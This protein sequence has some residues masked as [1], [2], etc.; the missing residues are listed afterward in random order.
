MATGEYMDTDWEIIREI[1]WMWRPNHWETAAKITGEYKILSL[2]EFIRYKLFQARGNLKK[3][4]LDTPW[5]LSRVDS[6]HGNE[7]ADWRI[8][9]VSKQTEIDMLFHNLSRVMDLLMSVIMIVHGMKTGRGESLRRNFFGSL[10]NSQPFIHEL[11]QKDPLLAG[12]LSKIYDSA[13]N[14]FLG[15]YLQNPETPMYPQRMMD[16]D[17][18]VNLE[19]TF[20]EAADQLGR[21]IINHLDGLPI[22]P[23]YS[24]DFGGIIEFK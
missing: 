5:Q 11:S 2:V 1:D 7:A 10:M 18:L 8:N 20:R 6:V 9:S 24:S 4:L 16:A 13:E 12:E 14:Q 17:Q 21:M 19:K 3:I 15:E 22:L 23:Q